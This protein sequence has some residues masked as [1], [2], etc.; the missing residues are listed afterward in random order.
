MFSGAYKEP[1]CNNSLR[2]SSADNASSQKASGDMLLD[3][4]R[5]AENVQLVSSSGQA[6]WSIVEDGV[7]VQF[8]ADTFS[9]L[10]DCLRNAQNVLFVASGSPSPTDSNSPSPQ[11]E[12]L[13]LPA[14]QAGASLL[15][16]HLAQAHSAQTLAVVWVE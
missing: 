6:R 8:T 7:L 5:S 11:D 12:S 9:T 16:V 15:A 14:N 13:A 2:P 4:L 3:Q 10:R 1:E